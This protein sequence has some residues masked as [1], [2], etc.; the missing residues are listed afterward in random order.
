MKPFELNQFAFEGISHARIDDLST[1]SGADKE[2]LIMSGVDVDEAGSR[3]GSFLHMD[4]GNVHCRSRHEAVEILDIKDALTKY[5][6]LPGHFWTLVDPDKDEYT[7]T[8][9][10]HLQ[11]GYFIKVAA[12]AKIA[13]PVQSCLFIKGQKAGQS[14]HNVVIVEEGAEVHIL[15]GCAVA[16]EQSEA[17]HVGVSEFFVKK[18]GKLTFSMIHNWG[19]HM[20]VVPRTG[21][22]VEAGGV[23]QNNYILLKQVKY[24]Q[25][26]PTITLAGPGAG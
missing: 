10:E 17:V 11:G 18:G 4:H 23:F 24:L 2:R 6:G 26:Y 1:I 16:N 7:R 9:N 5:D 3:A 22:I 13:T 19:E 25:S 15:T 14:V 20:N 12:G 21:G 8:A